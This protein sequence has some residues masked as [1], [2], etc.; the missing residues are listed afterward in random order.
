[1]RVSAKES[2]GGPAQAGAHL[3]TSC[4]SI[5][6]RA[7]NAVPYTLACIAAVDC[8]GPPCGVFGGCEQG[9]RTGE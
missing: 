4:F 6:C 9:V 8:T 3:P 5:A 1:V 2:Q 7:G